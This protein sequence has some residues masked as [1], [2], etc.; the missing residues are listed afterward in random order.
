MVKAVLGVPWDHARNVEKRHGYAEKE[1]SGRR[2]GNC[3]QV[4]SYETT[5]K[6]ALSGHLFTTK[7]DSGMLDIMSQLGFP[8]VKDKTEQKYDSVSFL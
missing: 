8:T 5:T 2:N 7:N 4:L 1:I 6:V 3:P